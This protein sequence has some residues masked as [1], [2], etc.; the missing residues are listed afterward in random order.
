MSKN[1]GLNALIVVAI[2]L[3]IAVVMIVLLTLRLSGVAPVTSWTA[4]QLFAPIWVPCVIFTALNTVRLL[5]LA[6]RNAWKR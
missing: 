3:T 2:L 1:T 4:G 6:M 5:A